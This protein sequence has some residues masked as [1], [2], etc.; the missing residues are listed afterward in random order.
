[1][2]L[3]VVFTVVAASDDLFQFALLKKSLCPPPLYVYKAVF[4]LLLLEKHCSKLFVS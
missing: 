1:M 4:K 3:P 2:L